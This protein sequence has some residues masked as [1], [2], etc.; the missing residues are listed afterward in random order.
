MLGI[1]LV[2][3]GAQSGE[4]M[5]DSRCTMDEAQFTRNALRLRHNSGSGSILDQA[6]WNLSMLRLLNLLVVSRERNIPIN[7]LQPIFPHSS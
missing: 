1:L 7:E 4:T 2:S 3:V 6:N 5:E